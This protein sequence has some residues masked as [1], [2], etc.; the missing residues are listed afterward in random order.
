M[1]DYAQGSGSRG[2]S[3]LPSSVSLNGSPGD[4]DLASDAVQSVPSRGS[5]S[6]E[7]PKPRSNSQLG[8][9][10][11]H[12]KSRG[13][14]F[15]CKRR[16]I[17]CQET[18]PSCLNCLRRSL[19]CKYPE[20]LPHELD[21]MT[22]LRRQITRPS[23]ALQST[24]TLFTMDDMRFFQHFILNAYPHLPVNNSQVWIQTVPA[25]SH[26][27]DYLMHSMLG[28]A[29]THLSAITNV[30]Y[31]DAALSHRVRAIEGFNKALSKK[32]EKEPDGDALLATM[33]SLTFQ[34]AFM[35]DSLIEFLIMVRGCVM[36]SG[37][38]LSQS[39][40]AF[41]VIDWY[42]HLRYME[43]RLDDLPFVDMALAEGAEAS[44]EALNFVLEDEVNS[45]YYNE[46]TNVV[47]G[48][49]AS[50]KLGYWRLVG[51]YNVMGMLSDANFGAFANPNNTIGQILL[52][53][54]MALEVV[55]LPMLEREYDKTFPTN[56]LIN[57]CSWF[58]S[59]E[60]SVPPEFRHFVRW[61]AEILN[62]AREKWKAIAMTS[63]LTILSGSQA[64]YHRSPS[65]K[66]GLASTS[67]GEHPLVLEWIS[68]DP[69]GKLNK[70]INA[71]NLESCQQLHSAKLNRPQT[72]DNQTGRHIHRQ[73]H[74]PPPPRRISP[75]LRI[76]QLMEPPQDPH[77]E[78]K[79]CQ[80]R[81]QPRNQHILAQRR[82]AP[83]P[84]P[85]RRNARTRHLDEEADDIATDKNP[86]QL[87][88]R[89]SVDP[90]QVAGQHGEAQAGDEHV[91]ARTDED[92]GYDYEG[93]LDR[94]L[95]GDGAGGI[96]PY[97]QEGANENHP[98]VVAAVSDEGL[99]TLDEHRDGVEDCKNDA[100]R[101]V[102]VVGPDAFPHLGDI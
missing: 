79:R 56:Q 77:K 36:L 28:L 97:F 84:V 31:S 47:S 18:L 82:I 60:R 38:L 96:A 83:L 26:N 92:R 90:R 94:V 72:Y 27:Y 73:Q 55:L 81:R 40:I 58:D 68:V 48:I 52:A 101:V 75:P 67:Q 1:F 91:V 86:R 22:V 42:S 4:T 93:A 10:K 54:F 30:D 33:Y 6:L 8:P 66:A 35:S 11:G 70:A 37:Q 76:R 69:K 41:F 100:D 44:L 16:K 87:A 64:G 15:S 24:P 102:G 78:Q 65:P 50:S 57:R 3:P 46:L 63:G 2:T 25:F 49:K 17:K 9:R 13:G 61:P 71:A 45:F 53:H 12:K 51:I 32:P 85:R 99:V 29:A 21:V 98:E 89:E 34:S 7:P 5:S 80:L 74:L 19:E 59:I 39:S 20:V 95:D 14:C 23:A 43:P 62:D 88:C